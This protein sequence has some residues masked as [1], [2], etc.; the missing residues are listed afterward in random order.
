MKKILTSL[1]IV[2]ASIAGANE[3]T[4]QCKDD[5]GTLMQPVVINLK[6]KIMTWGGF[7]L[8]DVVSL[9]DKHITL[10][11]KRAND[12]VGGEY[13]V[14]DRYDGTFKR[15]SVGVFTDKN[16]NNPKLDSWTQSGRCTQQK[17]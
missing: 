14:I 6:N 4:L 11:E 16:G 9:S 13:W 7:T 10:R 17:F 3:L 1:S 15:A 12:Q 5:S 8:Y 2:F